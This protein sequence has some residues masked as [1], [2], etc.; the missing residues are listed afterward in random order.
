MKNRLG[1][2]I[3]LLT[4]FT[5][6]LAFGQLKKDTKEPQLIEVLSKPAENYLFNLLD[7]SKVQMNHSFS[8]SFGM[9]GNSQMLQNSYVNT[10][11]FNLSENFTLKTDLGILSTPYHTFGGNSPLNNQQFFGG[12][13]LHYRISDKSSILFRF[14]S[15]PYAGYG[16]SYYYN[17]FSSP[18]YR[19]SYFGK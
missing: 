16:S 17:D 13:E 12:A 15:S 10:I 14:E 8:M 2:L 1:K 11:L 6:F 9:A 7:P 4:I 3:F 5:P 19:P 18:F